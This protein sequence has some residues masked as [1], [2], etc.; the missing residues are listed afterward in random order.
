MLGKI[1]FQKNVPRDL[2]DILSAYELISSA[3]TNNVRSEIQRT[4]EL[5]SAFPE[6]YAV[7]GNGIRLVKTKTYP[8]LIQYKIIG[9]IPVVLSIYH[10]DLDE[11]K[12]TPSNA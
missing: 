1:R 6:M 3:G 11:F 12:S 9:G 8:L 2:D 10:S 7:I 4:L 5:I